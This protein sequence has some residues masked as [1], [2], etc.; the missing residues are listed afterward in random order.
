MNESDRQRNWLSHWFFLF[1]IAGLLLLAIN[2]AK[3]NIVW[4]WVF[5]IAMLALGVPCMVGGIVIF[6]R[7]KDVFDFEPATLFGRQSN[8]K[9]IRSL[10][11][12]FIFFGVWSS[13][14]GTFLF[15][16]LRS[17]AIEQLAK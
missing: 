11:S 2:L 14:G 13:I 3:S 9:G 7:Y 6:N 1:F 10:L 5:A 15:F 12:A 17:G 16:M 8:G 4:A